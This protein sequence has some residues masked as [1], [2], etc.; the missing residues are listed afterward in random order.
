MMYMS[1]Y[2]NDNTTHGRNQGAGGQGPGGPDLPLETIHEPHH[3]E[4]LAD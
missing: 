3:F 1:Y 2:V 4:N